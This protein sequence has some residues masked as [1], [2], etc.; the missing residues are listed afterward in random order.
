MDFL[1]GLL[2]VAGWLVVVVILFR[3]WRRF[4]NRESRLAL[5]GTLLVL[6]STFLTLAAARILLDQPPSPSGTDSR[7]QL[8]GVFTILRLPGLAGTILVAY[9]YWEL[10]IGR[11]AI[12][13]PQ[14][15]DEV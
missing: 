4:P 10:V 6:G 15:R 9:A 13:S 3:A 7:L 14:R 11:R 1:S 2:G 12:Q 8:A 5:I